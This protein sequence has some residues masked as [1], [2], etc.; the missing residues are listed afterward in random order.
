MQVKRGCSFYAI[1]AAGDHVDSGWL[2]SHT[3]PED[4]RHL[5]CRLTSDAP[6]RIA[7]GIDVKNDIVQTQ[8]WLESSGLTI[9]KALKIFNEEGVETLIFTEQA[10]PFERKWYNVREGNYSLTAV[11]TDNN[12]KQTTSAPVAISV[13]AAGNS[14]V[15]AGKLNFSNRPLSLNVNPNPVA[16]TLNVSIYGL[17]TNNRSTISVLSV[18]G[19]IIKTI[20]SNTLNKNVQLDVSS[21]SAGVYFIKVISGDKVVYKQFVKL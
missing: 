14:I 5:L 19:V 16:K 1:T 20:Q 8:G 6:S 15:T 21:L 4:L 13:T 9:E 7:V 2:P 12:G 17:Q 18:S 3:A 10:A 11:A